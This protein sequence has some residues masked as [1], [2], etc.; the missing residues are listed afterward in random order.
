MEWAFYNNWSAKAEYLY[1]DLSKFSFLAP[2]VV[3]GGGD[4]RTWAVDIDTKMHIFCVGIN[5]RF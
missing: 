3:P 5:Y 1:V 2:N 4:T